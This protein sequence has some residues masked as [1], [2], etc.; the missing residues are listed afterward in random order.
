MATNPSERVS[1]APVAQGTRRPGAGLPEGSPRLDRH[2]T[3]DRGRYLVRVTRYPS[4]LVELLATPRRELTRSDPSGR[5]QAA[6]GARRLDSVHRAKANLRRRLMALDARYLLT[7]TTRSN[8]T[9]YAESRHQVS[10]YLR[11]LR[12]AYP[13][14]HYC[15]TPERQKRGA[16]H[17]HLGVNLRICARTARALWLEVCTDGNI[18][19]QH[20]SALHVARYVAK[21]IGKELGQ[22]IP[23]ASYIVSRGIPDPSTEEFSSDEPIEAMHIIAAANPEWSGE[24]LTLPEGRGYWAASWN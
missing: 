15:G 19:L 14:L 8:I 24:F 2:T 4:G 18:D 1:P 11:K 10:R 6:S 13:G 23:G 12:R 5:P 9:D 17:W 21:Y 16:W 3:Y 7:L 20:R 22:E